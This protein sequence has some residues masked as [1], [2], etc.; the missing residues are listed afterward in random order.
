MKTIRRQ[1]L[2]LITVNERI[3]S[4]MAQGGQ[5]T[6]DEMTLIRMCARELLASIGCTREI[7][8]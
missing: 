8:A 5:L 6:D 3:Q 4:V 7:L 2:N 1:I